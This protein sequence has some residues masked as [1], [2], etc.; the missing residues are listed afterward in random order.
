M[1][2]S[3]LAMVLVA[4]LLHALWNIAAKR[5]GG[6]RH[7]VMLG[8]QQSARPIVHLSQLFVLADK[9]RLL[10]D[11]ELAVHRMKLMLALAGVEN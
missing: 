1:P 10:S 6:D 4:A 8:G 3:A 2:L 7:F 9:A 11:P 5:A